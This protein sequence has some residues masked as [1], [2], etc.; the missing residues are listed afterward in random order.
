MIDLVDSFRSGATPRSPF[1]DRQ[2]D[3]QT[4][5]RS[6]PVAGVGGTNALVGTSRRTPADGHDGYR[7]A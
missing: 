5:G 4:Y 2:T 3:R 7:V 1:V 6:R